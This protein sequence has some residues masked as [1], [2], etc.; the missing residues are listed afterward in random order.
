MISISQSIASAPQFDQNVSHTKLTEWMIMDDQAFALVGNSYFK[1]YIESLQPCMILPSPSSLA[2]DIKQRYT[3]EK[4]KIQI[5]L[6]VMTMLP[7]AELLQPT[8]LIMLFYNS[9]CH[10]ESSG[11]NLLCSWLLDI[12]KSDPISCYRFI[13]YQCK[14][15][16][17]RSRY[18]FQGIKQSPHRKKSCG[19]FCFM[20][21][22]VW[23]PDQG[24]YNLVGSYAIEWYKQIIK[25]ISTDTSSYNWQCFQ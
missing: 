1:A 13:F 16:P 25:N 12:I 14:L 15:S 11:K 24:G 7:N 20:S 22:W 8:S 18:W 17:C 9:N 3:I 21:G 2:R 5:I 19:C 23:Y 4:Q 6:Q 10:L